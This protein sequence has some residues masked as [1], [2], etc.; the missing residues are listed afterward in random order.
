MTERNNSEDLDV[1]EQLSKEIAN[2]TS[3]KRRFQQVSTKVRGIL[4]INTTVSCLLFYLM[5]N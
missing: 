5:N 1:E 2:I 4:F 3:Q